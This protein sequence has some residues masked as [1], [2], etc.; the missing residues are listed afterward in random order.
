MGLSSHILLNMTEA[1]PWGW[2]WCNPAER[3]LSSENLCEKVG[4]ELSDCDTSLTPSGREREERLGGSILAHYV[5]P[6]RVLQPSWLSEESGS[7][8]PPPPHPHRMGLT[9]DPCCTRS[10]P[11]PLLVATTQRMSSGRFLPAL[12]PND[13]SNVCS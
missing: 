1:L 10:W 6:W 2:L 4:K 7:P 5:V 8:P 9:Q 13:L 3:Q 12:L 11:G